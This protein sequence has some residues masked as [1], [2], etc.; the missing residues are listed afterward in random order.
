MV[1]KGETKYK[2]SPPFRDAE[3]QQNLVDSFRLGGIDV[4]SSYH[5]FVP[6]R[7]KL[8]DNGNFRRAF[9]GLD[10]MGCS[11]QAL[12]TTLYN[13]QQKSE[14][15]AELEEK[16]LLTKRDNALLMQVYRTT[17][18]NPAKMLGISSK[19]GSIAKGKDADFVIWDPY[20]LEN[21]SWLSP[22]HTFAGKE[23]LGMVFKTY[24]RGNLIYS[25][26]VNDEISTIHEAEHVRV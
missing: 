11:L 1:K 3:N 12:W 15:E 18:Y 5:F 20:Q 19:K 4:M 10:S 9:G 22:N 8:V 21:N 13:D 6:P 26:D 7:Y 23:L 16:T 25:K 17:S 2:V 24:I 14:S